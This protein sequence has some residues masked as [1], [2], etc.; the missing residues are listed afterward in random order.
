ML[1][2][3]VA[4]LKLTL[5]LQ[6]SCLWTFWQKPFL[7]TICFSLSDCNHCKSIQRHDTFLNSFYLFLLPSALFSMLMKTISELFV[8]LKIQVTLT[9]MTQFFLRPPSIIPTSPYLWPPP[10]SLIWIPSH[11]CPPPFLLLLHLSLQY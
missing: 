9:V 3:R 1:K 4:P 7:M 8:N 2:L 6:T 5:D 11:P 10:Y